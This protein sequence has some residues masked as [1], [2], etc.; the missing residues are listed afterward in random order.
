ME[1][2]FVLARIR[3]QSAD[4]GEVEHLSISS[5]WIATGS[6]DAFLASKN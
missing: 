6:D 3:A 5:V 2:I 4:E 1:N